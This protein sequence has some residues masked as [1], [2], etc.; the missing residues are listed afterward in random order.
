MRRNVITAIDLFK[1][2]Y[3]KKTYLQNCKR[4]GRLFRA[5]TANIPTFCSDECKKAQNRENKRRFD[6]KA[7]FASY[8]SAYKVTYMYFYNRMVKLR[9]NAAGT[10]RLSRAE[11]AF[12]A[13]C[14]EAVKRKK[15][16]SSGQADTREFESWLL[17]QRDVIDRILDDI[18]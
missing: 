17:R 4:C 14:D 7:R 10:D 6:E 12:S 11:T 15:A 9:K 18:I 5:N 16:V 13:F 3:G 1:T 8:E 2:V